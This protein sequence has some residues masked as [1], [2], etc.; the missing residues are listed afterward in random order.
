MTPPFVPKEK[1]AQYGYNHVPLHEF[2]IVKATAVPL[3]AQSV[4]QME[5]DSDESSGEV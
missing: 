2:T 4:I 5:Q 1:G 3:M